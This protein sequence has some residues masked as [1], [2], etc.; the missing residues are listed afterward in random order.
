MA[1]RPRPRYYV[2]KM[3][4]MRQSLLVTV[5]AFAAIYRS[6]CHHAGTIQ[7]VRQREMD[8]RQ[9]SVTTIDI[10]Y[11]RALDDSRAYDELVIKLF[12]LSLIAKGYSWI[13]TFHVQQL[14]LEIHWMLWR[15]Q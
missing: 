1:G 3:N 13:A 7:C 9:N 10:I 11:Y 12:G 14:Q 2:T 15:M 4:T 6:S 5:V 8:G